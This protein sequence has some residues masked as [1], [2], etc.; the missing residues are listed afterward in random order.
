LFSTYLPW[1]LL[2]FPQIV[3]TLLPGV[4]GQLGIFNQGGLIRIIDSSNN[5]CPV[6]MRQDA[7][8]W[9]NAL[10]SGW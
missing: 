7:C 1:C 5:V 2:I 9:A 4:S 10:I 6:S 3:Q 8:S